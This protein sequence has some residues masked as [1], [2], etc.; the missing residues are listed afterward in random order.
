M[1]P[2]PRCGGQLF[3]EDDRT[4]RCKYIH[5]CLQCGGEQSLTTEEIWELTYS[6]VKNTEFLKPD[7]E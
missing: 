7:K 2:C 5:T 4:S 1:K 3:L 6:G